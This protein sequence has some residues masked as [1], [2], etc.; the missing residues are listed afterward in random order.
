MICQPQW[1]R[2]DF[3]AAGFGSRRK[4]DSKNRLNSR[5]ERKGREGENFATRVFAMGSK[6]RL[7]KFLIRNTIS[8]DDFVKEKKLNIIL[9]QELISL[10]FYV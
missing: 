9:G 2:L 7:R 5:S 10:G 4:N 1:E 3:T 8:L 6:H